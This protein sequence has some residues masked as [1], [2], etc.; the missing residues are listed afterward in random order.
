[1][2]NGATSFNQPLNKWNVS[3]VKS[4]FYMCRTP[5]SSPS[6]VLAAQPILDLVVSLSSLAAT[7][8]EVLVLI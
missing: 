7:P 6:S 3:N 8:R 1:M 5:L 4:M 2:F